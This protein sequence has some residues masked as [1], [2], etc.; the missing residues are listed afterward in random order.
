[1]AA[2]GLQPD[3]VPLP[4]NSNGKME[5]PTNMGDFSGMCPKAAPS[6]KLSVTAV[7]AKD[8]LPNGTLVYN[9]RTNQG[10]ILHDPTA[11][12]YVRSTDIDAKTGKLKTNVPVEP[13]VLRANAGDCIELTLA[14]QFAG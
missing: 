8:V 6:R 3:L 9:N 14:E 1:M 12:L 7:A 2:V 4:N 5:S 11:I 13:L 10:G